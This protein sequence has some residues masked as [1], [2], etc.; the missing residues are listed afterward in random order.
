MIVYAGKQFWND[1]NNWDEAL[2]QDAERPR[3]SDKF[4][5]RPWLQS[6]KWDWRKSK[7]NIKFRKKIKYEINK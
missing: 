6:G 4:K 1:F 3:D 7:T 5:L 2:F